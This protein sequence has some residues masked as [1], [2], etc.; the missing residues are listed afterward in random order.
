MRA[1]GF[2]VPAPAMQ[3]RNYILVVFKNGDDLKFT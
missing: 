2:L 3:Q 1:Y